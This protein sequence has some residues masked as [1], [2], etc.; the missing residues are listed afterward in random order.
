MICDAE[1]KGAAAKYTNYPLSIVRAGDRPY[2]GKPAFLNAGADIT[3]VIPAPRAGNL[4][5]LVLRGLAAR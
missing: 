3:P 2:E 1:Q 4:G 5:P